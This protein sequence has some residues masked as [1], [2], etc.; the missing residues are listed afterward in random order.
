[1]PQNDIV[2]HIKKPLIG[3]HREWRQWDKRLPRIG[4][5]LELGS[6]HEQFL[7]DDTGSRLLTTWVPGPVDTAVVTLRG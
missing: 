2:H 6:I 3:S 5:G 4:L 7:T 1:M